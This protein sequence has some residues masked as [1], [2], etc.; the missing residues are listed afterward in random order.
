MFGN[1]PSI[2]LGADKSKNNFYSVW[3]KI[4]KAP[5]YNENKDFFKE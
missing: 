4:Y 2:T 5:K 1:S 3:S